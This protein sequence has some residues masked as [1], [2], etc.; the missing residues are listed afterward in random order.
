MVL[1]KIS[2]FYKGQKII[3][4]NLNKRIKRMYLKEILPLI[5]R[6]NERSVINWCKKH[7]IAV[8]KDIS[9]KWINEAEFNYV[10]SLPTIRDFQK[11]Y[12]KDWE[13]AY[14]LLLNDEFYKVALAE[15]FENTKYKAKSK[16]TEIFLQKILK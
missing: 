15:T 10:Y 2:T 7:D 3:I 8:H 5:N 16:Q 1:S 13:S 4:K 11:K 6:R 12:G 9:G 14:N